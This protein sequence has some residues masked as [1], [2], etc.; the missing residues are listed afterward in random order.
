MELVTEWEIKGHDEA[1][2]RLVLC[3]LAHKFGPLPADVTAQV[4]ALPFEQL[5][6]LA[7][8]LLDFTTTADLVA[9]LTSQPPAS[10]RSRRESRQPCGASP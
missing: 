4:G 8:A 9:W 5:E 1:T 10:L 3:Q 7:D 6:A 2:R